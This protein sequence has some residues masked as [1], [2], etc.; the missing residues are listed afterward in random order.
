MRVVGH[1]QREWRARTG[2]NHLTVSPLRV[3]V[4]AV[5]GMSRSD[6]FLY[7]SGMSRSDVFL[8]HSGMSRFN[9]FLYRS[10]MSRSNVFLYRSG[11]SRCDVFFVFIPPQ[12]HL[13][14]FATNCPPLYIH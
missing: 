9:V 5:Y 12:R 3:D 1:W 13:V 14:K 4:T 6:V 8:Y 2:L 10:R 11:M 7:H